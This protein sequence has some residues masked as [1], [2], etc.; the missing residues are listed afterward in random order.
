MKAKKY[1]KIEVF[2]D[3]ESKLY[4]AISKD[5]FGNITSIVNCEY[6]KWQDAVKKL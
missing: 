4:G 6:K 1:Y 2:Q 5:Q 3:Q